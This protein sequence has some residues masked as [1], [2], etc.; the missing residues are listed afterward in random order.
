MVLVPSIS[1]TLLLILAALSL[2]ASTSGLTAAEYFVTKSGSDEAD[3]KSEATAFA[4]AQ[5]GVNALQA[6]DTLT[7]GPGEYAE[8]VRRVG[9][10]EAGKSTRIRARI[11]GTVVLRGDKPVGPFTKTPGYSLVYETPEEQE[12][13][14][15]SEEDTLT[16]LAL[17]PNLAELDLQPGGWFYDQNRKKLYVTG[18][19]SGDVNRHRYRGT[20][21]PGDGLCLEKA[22]TVVIDGLAA[23]GF[24]DFRTA[25]QYRREN[26]GH[27]TI[28][29]FFLYNSTNCEILN[30]TAYLNG[31]GIGINN[32]QAADRG[33][34]NRVVRCVAYGN[35]S[36]RGGYQSAGIGLY[37]SNGDEIR[38]CLAYKNMA[39]GLRT[40]L[41]MLRPARIV[42]SVSWNNFVNNIVSDIH[43]KDQ[44]GPKGELT[45][46]EGSVAVGAAQVRQ[47]KR[48]VFPEKNRAVPHDPGGLL[49]LP[50]S[51]DLLT[52]NTQGFAD[53]ANL[54]FRLQSDSPARGAGAQG[55]DLGAH[56]FRPEV[57]YV[58]ADGN[59]EADGL[60][61]AGA[62]K[63]LGR[64]IRDLE[65]GQTLYIE[66]GTYDE[67]LNV[68]SQ[69]TAEAPITVKGR[70]TGAV[71]LTGEV[72][73]SGAKFARL[74]RLNFSQT[75]RLAESSN[76]RLSQCQFLGS[77][78]GLS[79]EN[80]RDLRL[81]HN[82]FT[83]F[84]AAAVAVRGKT[85][86]FFLAGNLYDNR[87]G[88][89]VQLPEDEGL[90]YSD[91]N[92]Y[93]RS[94]AAFQIGEETRAFGSASD[95]HS[96]EVEAGIRR[97][98][99]IAKPE[100]VLALA[101]AGPL[102]KPLGVF[103]EDARSNPVGLTAAPSVHSVSATTANIEWKGTSPLACRLRW[104]DTPEC[105]NTV[106][107]E[108]PIV[109][110]YSLQGL[111][112]GK[113]YYF[114]M[115]SVRVP[116]A[117][118]GAEE[119]EWIEVNTPVISFTTA[120]EDA[121]PVT[122][123]VAPD[124]DDA[125][126]GRTR[127][128]AWR[129]IGHAASQV[130]VGDTV[131]IAGGTYEERVIIRATGRKDAPIT[132]AALPGEKV[133]MNGANKMLANGFLVFGKS[134]LRIDGFYFTDYAVKPSQGW[135]PGLAGD[136]CLY[137][138]EDIQ[139]TRCFSD[140]RGGFTARTL[141]AMEVKDLLVKNVVSLN[142]MSGALYIN[143]CENFRLENSVIA[144][145]MIASFILANQPS[146]KA[147]IKDN[148]FTDCL[149]KKAKLNT[150]LFD[151]PARAVHEN[152]VYFLRD[153]AHR[154][155]TRGKKLE[156]LG[157]FVK[158][159]FSGD[160]HFAGLIGVEL[161]KGNFPPDRFVDA[162]R[163]LDFASFF[164]TNPEVVQRK[165]G[166]QPEAFGL[167]EPTPEP[168]EVSAPTASQP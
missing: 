63:T 141:N 53:A 158:N 48:S 29:G 121:E 150:Q 81:E 35:G 47:A 167:P 88:V 166:L 34:D 98:D 108:A 68:S 115:D 33:G 162:D 112:P 128:K 87:Q 58:K 94:A 52:D 15:V 51:F 24:N 89:A 69:G 144:R 151:F 86:G 78:Q 39:M 149:E 168:A 159:P 26:A 76:L 77:P 25:P 90:S 11:P 157:S 154:E 110:T 136:F 32:T 99:G 12:I 84:N 133:R 67:N 46:V 146:Q 156:A 160:P 14:C 118:S 85:G 22:N 10:G 37:S 163:N 44:V 126:S 72:R 80:C 6:G 79:V 57:F 114:R 145:P 111:E 97:E 165:I 148:I 71:V 20:V 152:N 100:N 54:D 27:W 137:R 95:H 143:D 74:E 66:P 36:Q 75:L 91:Y 107:Y 28:W 64:A 147:L 132:F 125:N 4:T 155:L 117:Y 55:G 21:V 5:A 43:I 49:F 116:P 82:L 19:D 17:C 104:G 8:S 40:Y 62:W 161:G 96:R 7:I 45:S 131:L 1:R 109:G 16:P 93:A 101:G 129:T 9:L 113:T 138:G 83:G 123:Y 18:S 50:K 140:G 139:I 135:L 142:K 73:I 122:Y 102:G 60:S 61:V 2:L 31:G 153:P 23:T 164:A 105:R 70:G 3:G 124:G 42:D 13:L 106:S 56:V 65:P 134:H 127:D 59:D 120:P 92:G 119:T 38:E 41:Q 130:N 103:R 30:C